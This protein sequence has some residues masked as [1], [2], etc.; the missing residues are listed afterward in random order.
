MN[1]PAPIVP[2]PHL[3]MLL[4]PILAPLITSVV[5]L[6]NDERRRKHEKH[7]A[8]QQR[9]HDAKQRDID[10]KTQID[11]ENLRKPKDK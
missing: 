10:R 2:R 6:V 5:M 8:E 4:A 7:L 3:L 11:L 9:E 1:E